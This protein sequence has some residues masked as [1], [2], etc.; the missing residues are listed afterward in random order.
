MY[1]IG[2]VYVR[3]IKNDNYMYMRILVYLVYCNIVFVRVLVG[4]GFFW[5]DCY[6]VGNSIKFKKL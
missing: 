2:V 6:R 4:F 1:F 5:K 3:V